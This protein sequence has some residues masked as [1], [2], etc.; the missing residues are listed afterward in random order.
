VVRTELVLEELDL[1]ELIRDMV[2]MEMVGTL[3]MLGVGSVGMGGSRS[4]TLD[5]GVRCEDRVKA[6]D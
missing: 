6:R 3:R 5:R 1:D 2:W 4:T